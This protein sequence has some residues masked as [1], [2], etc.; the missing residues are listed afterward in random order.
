MYMYLSVEQGT[1]S[2]KLKASI[3]EI[4]DNNRERQEGT[5]T[6]KDIYNTE[7][8]KDSTETVTLLKTQVEQQKEVIMM[9]STVIIQASKAAPTSSTVSTSVIVPQAIKGL[10][11]SSW[12]SGLPQLHIPS[13]SYHL[14][15][16]SMPMLID[17]RFS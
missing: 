2:A 7:S 8:T 14:P 5:E 10:P 13:S 11:S 12:S 17:R 1:K 3:I 9:L 16:T 4:A 15:V 6:I